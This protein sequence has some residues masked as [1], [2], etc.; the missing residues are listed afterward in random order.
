MMVWAAEKVRVVCSEVKDGSDDEA[1]GQEA[2]DCDEGRE[3]PGFDMGEG[4][5]RGSRPGG[6]PP[7]S[8]HAL[9]GVPTPEAEAGEGEGG[10]KGEQSAAVEG[11]PPHR[12][13]SSTLRT[14]WTGVGMDV[15]LARPSLPQRTASTA[16]ERVAQGEERR[17]IQD[18]HKDYRPQ[19]RQ[20]R[21]ELPLRQHL[22]P[23]N[24]TP[25]R[26]QSISARVDRR[27]RHCNS[28]PQKVRRHRREQRLKHMALLVHLLLQTR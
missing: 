25:R 19:R 23:N 24:P 12:G 3:D 28:A 15:A 18:G 20:R 9:D 17:G 7:P 27:R 13:R 6:S 14:L 21:Q 11:Y 5:E 10:G 26:V 22:L 16:E 2:D 4:G 8:V 1:V